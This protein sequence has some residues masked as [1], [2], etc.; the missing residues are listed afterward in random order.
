MPMSATGAESDVTKQDLSEIEG[1]SKEKILESDSSQVLIWALSLVQAGQYERAIELAESLQHARTLWTEDELHPTHLLA[2]LYHEA[3]RND[4]AAQLLES[5][6]KHGEAV[7]AS[8][9]RAPSILVVL[10]EAYA[11]QERDDEALK[12]L[13]TAFNYSGSDRCPQQEEFLNV[14][15]RFNDDPRYISICERQESKR[16]QQAERVRAMLAEHDI[17]EL[18]APLMALV[19]EV[20]TK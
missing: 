3:G 1:M 11:L 14:W 2:S 19:D 20:E 18:L 8:G 12:M 16:K 7:F 5:I 15:A 9:I 17:D 13:R 6:V 4:D 10:A